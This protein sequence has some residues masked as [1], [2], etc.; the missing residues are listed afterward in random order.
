MK[1]AV[2]VPQSI[3]LLGG[4]SEIGL[5]IVEE[6]LAKGTQRVVLAALPNDPLREQAVAQ[7]E[8]AGATSVE[9]IDFDATDFDGHAKTIDAAFSGGDIDVAIVAFALDF[10]AEEL[11]QN[12]RKAVL[13]AQVNYTGAV[14][15]GVLLG[16]KIKEQGHG[17]I[18]AMSSVAGLRPRRSNF[19]YGSSK[20]GFD[21][22]YLNLGQALEPFGGSVLVVRPGMVR[23]KFSAHV[24][25][26][27]LTIDKDVIGTLAVDAAIKGKSLVYAP[28]PWGFVSFGLKN[29]PQPIFKKLPI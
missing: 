10:D 27:P 21:G 1:N 18:I 3:L 14:S 29:I 4:T 28:A 12:Q 17:Q 5:S 19:V 20:A 24:K 23:T 13:L 9:V 7:V 6:Y 2:G 15:V 16:Q 22:F 26:A 11:W 25:E 8:A